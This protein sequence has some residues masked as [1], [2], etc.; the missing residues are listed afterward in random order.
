LQ[1]TAPATA[2]SRSASSENDERSVAAE[3][4]RHLLH[5]ARALLHQELSHLG[6]AGEAELAHDRIRRQLGTDHGRVV[7][8]ARDNVEHAGRQT[9][10]LGQLRDRQRRE[11]RLL[12]RLE[13]HG[14]TGRDRRG[15]LASDHR[16]GGSSTA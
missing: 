7:S 5:L 14:A 11:R 8:V 15:R 3:L 2:S 1:S 10:F 9:G 12:G 13:H 16:G 4:E 6:R